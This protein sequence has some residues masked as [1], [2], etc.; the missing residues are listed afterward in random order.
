MMALAHN[1]GGINHSNYNTRQQILDCTDPISF[2]GIYRNVYENQDILKNKSGIFFVMG[3]Y[4][5][6][7]NQFDLHNVPRLETYC[8]WEEINDM[9]FKYNF[10]IGWHTWSH[11]DLTTL[12]E[13]DILK[14]ITPPIPMDTFAYPYGRY[15]DKVI[16]LVKRV[17]YKKAF[18]VTQGATDINTRDYNYKIFRRYI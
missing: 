14:E 8:T 11:P 5:G 12:S 17:G 9:V 10:E 6:K 3:N 4:V 13:E 7:D 15:S 16:E 18:S 2:D 1:V